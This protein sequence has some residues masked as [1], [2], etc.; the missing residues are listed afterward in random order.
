MKC[1][2]WSKTGEHKCRPANN[3]G[4]RI[5]CPEGANPK[6]DVMGGNLSEVNK[7]FTIALKDLALLMSCK[8]CGLMCEDISEAKCAKK[9]R[10]KYLREVREWAKIL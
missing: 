10:E 3:G 4:E 7:A 2:Y 9:L 6:C 1:P 5:P 8:E